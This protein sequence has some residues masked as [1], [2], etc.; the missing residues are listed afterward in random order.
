MVQKI[1]RVAAYIRV[2]TQEQK[3]HGLSLD[4][5]RMR[6]SEY[7]KA[8]NMRIVGW[9]TDEGVSGRKLI[10]N[11]PELQ[12]MI[13]D[14][15]TGM[16]DRIIFI[17]LDRFFRSVAEYHECMKRISP[18]KWTTTEEE[19]DLT[20]ANGRMLVNMKLTIA[21]LE[22]DQTGERIRIVNEYKT[23]VGRP[24]TGA[25]P[26]CFTIK[27]IDGQKRIVKNPETEHRMEDLLNH[28]FVHQSKRKTVMY[29]NTKYGMS[30]SCN[31]IYRLLKN[32]L[33]YGEYR[34]NP[35]YISEENRYLSKAEFDKMQNMLSRQVKN[36]TKS[37][38]YIFSGLIRCPECG[39]T[40]NGG[41]FRTTRSNNRYYYYKKYRCHRHAQRGTCSFAK[42]I[43]ENTLEKL[44]LE[45]IE[46][47]L[48]EARLRTAEFVK[49]DSVN[50]EI[51]LQNLKAEL[52]RL[53]YSWQKGRIKSAEKYDEEYNK[54]SSKIATL[55]AERKSP[56][57]Q[58]FS[59]AEAALSGD[60]RHLYSSLD[61][62]HKRSFWRSF[63]ESIEVDWLN[64]N[65]RSDKKI[66][67][68]NFF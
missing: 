28:I 19:Y 3:L 52:E 58:N 41:T 66:S 56:A 26:F 51:E 24:L 39:A 1:E 53:N 59:K 35:N 22:A 55:D 64:G 17:K 11:R 57:K 12:R 50:D 36:N 9:Y 48:Q 14:A 32:P 7:A 38:E 33:L 61:D 18:V 4:A 6:L 65:R 67:R 27:E 45:N 10:K 15:E 46:Q 62:A 16:F 37:H 68:V 63:I 13:N 47:Y 20:T 25:L 23:T 40:L 2:S 54:L 31:A 8:H 5:Q 43:S 29:M 30:I 21:E 49:V 34:G 60:W 42:C 44:L